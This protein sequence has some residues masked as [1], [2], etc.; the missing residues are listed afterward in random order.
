LASFPASIALLQG[1]LPSVAS[2]Q[3]M[4]TKLD[5]RGIR[6]FDY[7][8]QFALPFRDAIRAP[9]RSDSEDPR[10]AWEPP[11]ADS[12]LLANAQFSEE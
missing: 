2:P 11:R 1:T 9:G 6:L 10:N 8:R 7:A 12:H 5:R 4:A 3:A